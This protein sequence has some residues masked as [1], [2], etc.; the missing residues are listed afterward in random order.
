MPVG[1]VSWGTHMATYVYEAMN[2]AG[3]AVKDELEA[4]GKKNGG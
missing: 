3:Q 1:V 4:L 2:Q